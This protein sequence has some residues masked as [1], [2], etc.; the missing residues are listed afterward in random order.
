LHELS[1]EHNFQQIVND[2]GKKKERSEESAKIDFPHQLR[3]YLDPI[4]F[5]E[6]SPNEE[7][8]YDEPYGDSEEHDAVESDSGENVMLVAGLPYRQAHQ[9]NKVYERKSYSSE[10]KY[11]A[12][13]SI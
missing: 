4:Q 12:S 3:L 1:N 5:F 6:L 9:S 11:N 7:V 13:T 2:S 10:K 8:H